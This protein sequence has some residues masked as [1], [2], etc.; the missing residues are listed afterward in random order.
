ML[1]AFA[2]Y[3]KHMY[4][5]SIHYCVMIIV[6]HMCCL[7]LSHI[8]ILVVAISCLCS[9]TA[10]L[11]ELCTSLSQFIR[12]MCL[13]CW[14]YLRAQ[15]YCIAAPITHIYGA[16]LSQ[17]IILVIDTRFALIITAQLREL[18]TS[19]SLFIRKI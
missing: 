19:F 16:S 15:C 5:I 12:K 13:L 2:V 17:I 6:M 11:C 7:R 18:C 4:F 10:L 1:I 9:S 8:I 3:Q 14:F